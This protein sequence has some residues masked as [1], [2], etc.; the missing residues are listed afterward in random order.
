M[1]KRTIAPDGP[2]PKEAILALTDA[3]YRE[4]SD[5]LYLMPS[6]RASSARAPTKT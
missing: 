3:L 4:H 2:S 6:Y 5:L 1:P